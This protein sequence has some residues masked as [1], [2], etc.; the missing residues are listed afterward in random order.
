VASGKQGLSF[1]QSAS[2]NLHDH[3]Q[4]AVSR[5]AQIEHVDDVRVADG[6]GCPRFSFEARHQ[7]RIGRG[8]R[9]QG[10]HRDPTAQRHVHRLVDDAH[11]AAT[12]FAQ[13]AIFSV[14][15]LPRHKRNYGR[16][17]PPPN[18]EQAPLSDAR[19]PPQSWHTTDPE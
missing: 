6:A 3:E 16:H 15:D 8:V 2:Q 10:F 9:A 5:T 19:A 13:D 12:D 4:G 11:G 14:E 1:S 18:A 17:R 7:V